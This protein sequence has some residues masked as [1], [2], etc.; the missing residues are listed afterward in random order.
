M[1]YVDWLSTQTRRHYRLPSEA[2]WEYAARAG[3]DTAYWFGD[4]AAQICRY[5]NLGDLDTRDR[6]GW[7][8]MHMSYDVLQDWKGEPC[9]DGFAAMAPVAATV[10]NPL[11]VHG[12]LGNANEWVADCWNDDHRGAPDTQE[13][14][15]LGA[16]CGQRVM[17]GQGWTA[18]AAS[19]R[20][21]FRLKMVATDRRFTFG[22][23]VVRDHRR[24]PAAAS[25]RFA[26]SS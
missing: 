8:T 18:I 21:A 23:R 17:K 7:D 15:L 25:S 26:A 1:A 9:R 5:I 2:E 16:D 11:G 14:R 19:V 3:I 22:F 6:F 13:P 12:L 20:P 10:A 4:D 24:R